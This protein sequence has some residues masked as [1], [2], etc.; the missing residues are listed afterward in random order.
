LVAAKECNC[1]P[2]EL[3]EQSVFWQDVAIKKVS[4]EASARETLKNREK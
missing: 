4:A 1:T 2:W 3:L